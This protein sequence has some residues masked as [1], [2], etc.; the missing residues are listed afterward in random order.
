MSNTIAKYGT[1]L[2]SPL[3]PLVLRAFL[4][5]SCSTERNDDDDLEWELN[6]ALDEDSDWENVVLIETQC[7]EKRK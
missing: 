2:V 1:S 5:E 7:G 4:E 6:V 3:F